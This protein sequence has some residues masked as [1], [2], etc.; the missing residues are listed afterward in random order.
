MAMANLQVFHRYAHL[1]GAVRLEFVK[2]REGKIAKAMLTAI[3]NTRRGSGETREEESTAIQWTAVRMEHQR[4]Q[5]AA[6]SDSSTVRKDK[7]VSD[8]R[9]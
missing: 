2:G 1:A 5:R 8:F 6:I 4:A 3:G 7:Q 9:R